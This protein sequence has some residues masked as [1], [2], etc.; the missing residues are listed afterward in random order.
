MERVRFRTPP[1]SHAFR[2]TE[3]STRWVPRCAVT[4]T[5][6]HRELTGSALAAADAIDLASR[7][8]R[9]RSEAWREV[10]SERDVVGLSAFCQFCR[11][12]Q[13]A[14]PFLSQRDVAVVRASCNAKLAG[15]PDAVSCSCFGSADV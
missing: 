3:A 13:I 2:R 15:H 11:D 9:A 12:F 8:A 10:Q 1:S 7:V 4:T 6:P 5:C 14:P